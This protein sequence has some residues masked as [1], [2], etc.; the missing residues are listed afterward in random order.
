MSGG[1]VFNKT[2]QMIEDRLSLNSVN[3]KL[4]SG[5]LANIN[6]PGYTAQKVSRLKTRCGSRFRNT[7]FI[8]FAQTA[9][10]WPRMILFRRWKP[11][12]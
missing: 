5:N 11:R 1:I 10:I 12:K 8:W 4:I 7:C 2:L 9:A 3:Q 6:T